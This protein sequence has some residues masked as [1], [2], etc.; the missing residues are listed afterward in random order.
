[1]NTK[2]M[3][4]IYAL[5]ILLSFPVPSALANSV[6]T[7]P[8]TFSPYVDMTLN[9]SWDPQSQD[10]EPM[11]LLKITQNSGVKNYHL[12]FIT[13]AGNCNPAWGGQSTYSTK[14][15]WA[16]HLT[17]KLHKNNINYTIS[18][19]GA[20]NNDISRDCDIKQLNTIF[21]Q[22]ITTYQ[23]TAFDFDI[24]NGSAD[25]SKL[26]TALH[27]FQQYHPDIKLSFTLPVMPEG[28]TYSGQDILQQA[29]ASSLNFSV[30][31]MAMDYGPGY[32]SDMGQYAI[33][34]SKNLF[35]FLQKLYPKKS[36]VEVWRMIEV[37]PMIGV[38]DVNVEQFTLEN[39]DTLARFAQ[40][41]HLGG[42]SLWSIARDN[43]C[44][45]KWAS[46]ICSGNNLQSK[47]YEFSQRF[48][49]AVG[50]V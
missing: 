13:D 22:V 49:Q 46:N 47:P 6:P 11:D 15:G 19:G 50:T 14:D 17:D 37:T 9:V 20:N 28:L 10:L 32:S 33:E 45:D 44:A 31:I 24:E 1:M 41:N 2:I 30:N 36:D 8:L 21:E 12:A 42:L 35:T 25:V 7:T 27:Q 34:A 3:S 40:Q 23:P 29:Q 38:N 18:F 26:M 43:P 16:S 4:L 5:P 39:V 48:L